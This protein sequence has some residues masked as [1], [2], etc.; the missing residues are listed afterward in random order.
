MRFIGN[1]ED[2]CIFVPYSRPSQIS[3]VGLSVLSSL[4]FPQGVGL[5]FDALLICIT[6]GYIVTNKSHNRIAFLKMLGGAG[7][8]IFIPFFSQLKLTKGARGTSVALTNQQSFS[9]TRWLILISYCTILIAL[10]PLFSY[11]QLV[12]ITLQLI[13]TFRPISPSARS[14]SNIFLIHF[15]PLS[16][17]LLLQLSV[18]N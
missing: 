8:Y 9:Q 7:S 5:N 17:S 4:L 18:F 2:A 13:L 10:S 12:S 3:L 15:A 6:A 16:L 1:V 11:L 14:L